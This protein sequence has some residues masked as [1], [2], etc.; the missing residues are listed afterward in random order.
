MPRATDRHM[1]AIED[2]ARQVVEVFRGARDPEAWAIA[3]RR[4][5]L[6]LGF[7]DEGRALAPPE[8]HKAHVEEPNDP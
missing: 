3:L 1:H 5:A 2:R 6:L 7:A 8:A 4:A